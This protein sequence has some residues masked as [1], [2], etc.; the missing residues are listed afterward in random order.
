MQKA[1]IVQVLEGYAARVKRVFNF[2]G[3]IIFFDPS[4]SLISV[5]SSSFCAEPSLFSKDDFLSYFYF[6]APVL[7][8]I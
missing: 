6:D 2:F 4:L 5:R 1:P 3:G 7:V 8:L